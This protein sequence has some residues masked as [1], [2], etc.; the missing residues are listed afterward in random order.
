MPVGAYPL[1]QASPCLALDDSNSDANIVAWSMLRACVCEDT[2][3]KR[4]EPS[5]QP[6]KIKE[7]HAAASEPQSSKLLIS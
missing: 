2:A 3:S 7:L 4:P 5:E 1:F 6:N